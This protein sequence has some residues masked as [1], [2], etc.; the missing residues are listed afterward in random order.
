[1]D[2]VK[3]KQVKAIILILGIITILI[4]LCRCFLGVDTTDEAL[5]ISDPLF[6]A[7]GLTPYVN[8]WLQTPGFSFFLAP[9]VGLYELFFP[10]HQGIFLFM[11]LFFL[12]AKILVYLAIYLLFR[13]TGYKYA[14]MLAAIP[15]ISSFFGMIPSFNY[16]NIPLLG[17]F[18]AGIL[19]LYQWYVKEKRNIRLLPFINGIILACITLCSPTQIFNCIVIMVFYFFFIDK[20]ACWRYVIGGFAT[21]VLFALYMTIRAGSISGLVNSLETFLNHPYFS[22]GASTLSWQAYTIF[23]LA[24]EQLIPYA[25]CVLVIELLRRLVIKKHSFM[26]SCRNGLIVGAFCGLL[27]NLMRYEQYALWNRAIILLSIGSFFFRIISANKELRRLFDF[28]AI[29]EMFA[30]LGMALTVYGGAANRFYVFTP[31]ALIC[32]VYIYDALK[33]QIEVRSFYISAVYVCLFLVVI[34][35]YEFKTIYGEFDDSGYAPISVITTQIK[36]GIYAGIYTTEQK[37]AALPELETYIRLNTNA[38]EYVLFMDRAPMAY[39]M[40]DANACSPTSWDPVLYTEGYKGEPAMLWDYFAVVNQTPDKVIYIHTSSDNPI[41]I[42]QDNNKLS[43]YIK[44]NYSLEREDMI[45]NMYRVMIYVR[46][47]NASGE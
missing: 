19:L 46:A 33:E 8:N 4:S 42:E 1:M 10:E 23:P 24:I 14:A 12:A 28:V 17:L 22:F 36:E 2:K 3:A 18:M 40:T 11:R 15:L 21:A 37:A 41:S 9:V 35:K 45:E 30:F 6:V 26:W 7:H 39:L 16:T 43:D 20:R 27:I 25:V 31:M 32:L 29:P 34:F 5:Y 38:E 47:E 44:A 13:N